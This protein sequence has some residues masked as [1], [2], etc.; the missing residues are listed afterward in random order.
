MSNITKTLCGIL[1]GLGLSMATAHA[2]TIVSV[3]ETHYDAMNRPDCVAVRMNTATFGGAPANGCT[4]DA[5]GN[6]GPDRITHNVYDN[7]GQV[8]EVDQAYGTSIQ[9]AYARYSYNPNGTKATEMDANGNKTM[10]VYDGF[11][12]LSQLQYP[13]TTVG[14]GNI[15]TA[16]YELFG[17]DANN[18]RISW[19]RRNGKTISYGYDALNREITRAV[20]D[21]SVQTVY[22]GYDLLGDVLFARY[23]STSGAGITNTYDGLARLSTT[24]DMNSRAISYGY[25][26]ASALV[27]LIYPDGNYIANNLDA[28]NR[29]TSNYLDS[30]TLLTAQGY[31]NLGRRYWL[32]HGSQP[33]TQTGYGYDNLGRLTSLAQ[34]LNG[35]NGSGSNVSWSFTYTPANQIAS[36]SAS[37]TLYDYQETSNSTVNSTYDGLNRDASIAALSGGFDGDGNLTN[38]GTR[39]FTYDVYN[40]LL[41]E[42]A[43][44]SSLSLVYDPLG[45]LASQTY[46]GTTTSFLYDGTNLIAE[47]NGSGTM[48]DRYVHGSGTDEPQVWFQGSQITTPL[49]FIQDYHGSVIGYTDATGNMAALYKYGPYG[50]PKDANNAT[51]FTGARFRYTGQMVIPE[52]SLYYYKARV[53]DPIFGRFLQTDPIGSKDDL[54][55]YAYTGDDPIDGSD[56][57]GNDCATTNGTTT[58]TTSNYTV[59]FPAQKGFQDFNSN[60]QDYH[61]Y[62][63]PASTPGQTLQQDQAFLVAHPTPGNPSPAFPQGTLNDATPVTGGETSKNISPVKSFTTTNQKDGQQVVVNVTEPGHPLQSGIVVREAQQNKD[64]TT[65]IQNWGE[66]TSPLQSKTSAAGVLGGIINS[67]W[68]V[69][70]PPNPTSPTSQVQKYG[71]YD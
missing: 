53:Y 39:A 47:Y 28:L 48:L 6:Y 2:D 69:V 51:D 70:A 22:T 19:R 59:S 33:A 18:N 12:R 62:N 23:G 16:D 56:P 17:Y 45:R 55:L 31:D 26:Q 68:S 41:T 44:G 34:Y 50:E 32:N 61:A 35:S 64:G 29:L 54:D 4:L 3:T 71:P 5:N 46:N 66:G 37:S 8:L 40:H 30:S 10:Y 15:D 52:A 57:T 9:R 60:S 25:N 49:Y 58:C 65:M 7:V 20:S 43:A 11:D 36:T 1:L 13:S 38:D 24:T 27:T 14:S 63:V 67:I 42:A 21:G